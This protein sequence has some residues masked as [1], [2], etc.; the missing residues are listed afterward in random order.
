MSS[1]VHVWLMNRLGFGVFFMGGNTRSVN[2][3]STL[4]RPPFSAW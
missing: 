3:F 2:D 4:R 1:T